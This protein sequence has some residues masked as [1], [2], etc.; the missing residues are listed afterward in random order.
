MDGPLTGLVKKLESHVAAVGGKSPAGRKVGTFVHVRDTPADRLR[1]L[2]RDEAIRWVSLCR[3]GPPE[4]YDVHPDAAVTVLVYNPERR[5][6]QAV[7]ANFALRPGRLD[8][9]TT[10]AIVA[11]VAEVL[12][13]K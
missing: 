7:R 9:A 1:D 12:P 3:M 8:D 10:D 5:N 4:G 13:P 2:A 6:K 11:A